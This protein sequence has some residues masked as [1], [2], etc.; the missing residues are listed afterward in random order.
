MSR[1]AI[2]LV[3]FPHVVRCVGTQLKGTHSK[4]SPRTTRAPGQ[5]EES[6]LPGDGWKRYSLSYPGTSWHHTGGQANGTD[7]F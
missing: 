4:A 1:R 5:A 7:P 3:L 6:Y 2:V